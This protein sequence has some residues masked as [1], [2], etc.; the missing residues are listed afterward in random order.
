MKITWEQS[1]QWI[2]KIVATLF[3]VSIGPILSSI[4]DK[5]VIRNP[6]EP[7]V[8]FIYALGFLFSAY[9]LWLEVKHKKLYLIEKITYRKEK[10]NGGSFEGGVVEAAHVGVTEWISKI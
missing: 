9:R 6:S 4:L 5:F 8:G 10:K 7:L 3:N 1:G 2:L